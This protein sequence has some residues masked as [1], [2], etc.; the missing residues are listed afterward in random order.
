VTHPMNKFEFDESTLPDPELNPLLNPILG[1]HM[2][3]WA[4]VYFT[5]PPEKR[6]QAISELLR[7]LK[8]TSASE[9]ASVQ[10]IDDES[11][12][13][14][15]ETAVEP[16]SFPTAPEPLR[17]CSVCAHNNSAEQ[18]F[19]GMCGAPLETSA[20]SYPPEIAEA[21]Q[22]PTAQ[23]SEPE[24][25]LGNN[26]LEHA[27]EPAVSSTAVGA[28][29]DAL[30]PAWALPERSLPHFSVESE[31]VPHR[32][33]PYLGVALAILLA[34]LVYMGWRGTR[35]ISGTAGT[36]PAPARAISAAQPPPAASALPLPAASPQPSTAGTTSSGDN[37]PK[38]PVRSMNQAA[39][40][41]R[42]SRPAGAQ[43]ASLIVPIP[44]TSSAVAVDESGA[45]DLA[46]AEKYLDGT[47][48][49]PRHS[50][51]AAE[52]LWK[53]VGKGN[54]AATLALSDLYLRGDGVPK[55]CDQA[56]L[57]L[58]A[59]ARKGGRSAADRLRNLRA[60]GCE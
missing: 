35:A 28:G 50:G 37:P 11:V 24:P 48:G 8:N 7:E 30:G 40:T 27:I 34:L 26:P 13:E 22:I 46:T 1:A 36:P 20:W 2:G 32:Y 25:S 43:P 16:D 49:V 42:K 17:T 54:L 56:R 60:F 39:A 6:G 38:S 59:A 52:W 3:R 33:R 21:L 4:E 55:S 53:A 14:K 47:R 57:L 23:W 51:E 10:V 29:R 31:P 44:A 15:T 9:S 58:D 19:C 45:E 12:A 5:N 41:S 18:R